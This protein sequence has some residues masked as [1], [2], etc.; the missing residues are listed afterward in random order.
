MTEYFY[1]VWWYV[2][3]YDTHHIVLSESYNKQKMA[4]SYWR[5]FNYIF[6]PLVSLLQSLEC[7]YAR[8]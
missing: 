2:L 5:T 7:E 1:L 8:A 3:K 4:D 6:L